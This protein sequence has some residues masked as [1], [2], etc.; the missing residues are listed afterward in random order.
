LSRL[1][2]LALA[3]RLMGLEGEANRFAGKNPFTDVPEWGDRLTAFAFSIGV[4][5][6]VDNES[7]D[8]NAP[9]TWRQFTAFLLRVLGHSEKENDFAHEEAI[10]KAMDIGMLDG[11]EAS[12]EEPFK[13]GDAVVEMV[14]ALL[15]RLDGSEKT[16]LLKLVDDG[17]LTSDAARGFLESIGTQ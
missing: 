10:Q 1:E 11:S 16:L 14:E 13:R 2:A 3:I 7:F 8:P 4:A 15:A 6:G 17:V 9:V 12:V 5:F